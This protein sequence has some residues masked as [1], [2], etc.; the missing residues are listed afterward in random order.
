MVVCMR[1]LRWKVRMGE[2]N[3][4][5]KRNKLSHEI[6][7][8]QFKEEG[9]EIRFK[10]LYQSYI[11]LYVRTPLKKNKDVVGIPTEHFW[12]FINNNIPIIFAIKKPE[13]CNKYNFYVFTKEDIS[14]F[15]SGYKNGFD[16]IYYRVSKGKK[17][18]KYLRTIKEFLNEKE[19]K[20]DTQTSLET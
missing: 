4:V 5:K 14:G 18:K 7:F 3:L 17:H 10:I 20:E 13:E 16:Y 11:P 8:E 2:E 9:Y 6:A 1:W 15:K 12:R 19:K